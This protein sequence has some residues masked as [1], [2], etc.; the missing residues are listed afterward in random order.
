[1]RILSRRTATFAIFA[2]GAAA[3][4]A[5]PPFKPAMAKDGR[6]AAIIAGVALGAAALAAASRS[7][8]SEYYEPYYG[9]PVGVAPPPPGYAYV[10]APAYG[11]SYSAVFRPYPGVTCYPAQRACYKANGNY[12]PTISGRIYGY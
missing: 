8:Q 1:M 4:A 5:L 7:H 3:S 6:N 10:P 11:Y 12:S 2:L 9:R